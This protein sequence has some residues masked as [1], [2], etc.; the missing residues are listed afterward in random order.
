MSF[1]VS[2]QAAYKRGATLIG[3]GL[4]VGLISVLALAAITSTGDRVST[5]FDSVSG[6]MQAVN[7]GASASG[8]VAQPS[9]TPAIRTSCND[10]AQNESVTPGYEVREINPGSGAFDALCYFDDGTHGGGGFTVVLAQYEAD[11]ITWDEGRQAD[12]Q[13]DLINSPGTSFALTGTDMPSHSTLA[14]GRIGSGANDIIDAIPYSYAT[15]NI[16]TDRVTSAQT[17]LSYD[18]HRS[19]GATFQ[20]HDPESPGGVLGE[21]LDT[22]TIDQTGGQQ[23]TWAFS[24]N[25]TAQQTKGYAYQ[26]STGSSHN[27]YAW[28]LMVR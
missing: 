25:H 4:V 11:P 5:L 15:G 2:K 26:G 9:P 1:M 17:S 19:D 22:L 20:A 14:F 23:F 24:P 3:Y 12:Y 27:S 6:E 10:I 16:G 7:E 28:A 8:V 21:W 18:I 13:P